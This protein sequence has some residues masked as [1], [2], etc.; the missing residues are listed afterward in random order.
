MK[1]IIDQEAKPENVLYQHLST[2]RK[3]QSWKTA[4][5]LSNFWTWN[6]F[7]I[8]QPITWSE[9]V[10]V[11]Q[12]NYWSKSSTVGYYGAPWRLM[13]YHSYLH[14]KVERIEGV[15]CLRNSEFLFWTLPWFGS[16]ISSL[17]FHAMGWW[18]IGPSS[19]W[20]TGSNFTSI[21]TLYHLM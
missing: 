13:C 10:L 19:R 20:L 17:F 3:C 18:D 5:D 2:S 6:Q 8:R 7:P 11:G 16:T 1:K 4:R 14:D 9:K 15:D 21:S 12:A